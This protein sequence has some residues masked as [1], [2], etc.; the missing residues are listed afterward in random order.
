MICFVILTALFC[1]LESPLF[2]WAS[3]KTNAS[4]PVTMAFLL[5]CKWVPAEC[6]EDSKYQ[7]KKKVYMVE[8]KPTIHC[9]LQLQTLSG[10]SFYAT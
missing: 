10:R 2:L 6:L 8:K 7:G 4:Y 9:P 1:L 3:S 5:L